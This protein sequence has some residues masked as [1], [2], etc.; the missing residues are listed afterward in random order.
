L[1]HFR[2][3]RLAKVLT[4]IDTA[5]ASTASLGDQEAAVWLF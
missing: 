3:I 2:D 4:T 5:I 1:D